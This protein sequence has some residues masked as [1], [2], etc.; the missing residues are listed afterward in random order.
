MR[1][2]RPF[3]TALTYLFTLYQGY[4]TSVVLVLDMV[5]LEIDRDR[6][7]DYNSY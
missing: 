4:G 7:F 5:I 2:Q 3:K 1:P 6:V